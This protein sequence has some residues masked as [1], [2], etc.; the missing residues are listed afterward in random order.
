M[1]VLQSIDREKRKERKTDTSNPDSP[2]FSIPLLFSGPFK[3][4]LGHGQAGA[5]SGIDG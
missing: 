2:L 1:P 3:E 5:I 4:E